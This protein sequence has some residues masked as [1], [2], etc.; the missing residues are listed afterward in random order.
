MHPAAVSSALLREEMNPIIESKELILSNL[1]KSYLR[2]R[3]M[4]QMLLMNSKY[5]R[6]MRTYYGLRLATVTG[7][8]LL[9][10]SVSL[11]V[12]V[13]G[14]AG[15]GQTRALTIFFSLLIAACVMIEHL[16]NLGET[17]RRYERV[18]ERLKAEGWRF[19]QLS[20]HYQSYKSHS[21]AFAAFANQV[22]ALNQMD[23]E[24][25]NF[26]VVG[27]RRADSHAGGEEPA[28]KLF[29]LEGIGLTD[30]PAVMHRPAV[31]QHSTH[32]RGQ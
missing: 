5:K 4:E 31:S 29:P 7:S 14:S 22:E 26:D 10:L 24:V 23:V 3:W 19:L 8:L 11:N 13:E 30:S 18:S 9:L 27:G 1:Q 15:G 32:Q 6:A 17:H 20:G 25:Y 2:S 28:K 21:D 16:F 12:I